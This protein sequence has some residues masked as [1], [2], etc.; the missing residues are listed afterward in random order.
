MYISQMSLGTG[1]Y[2]W[3]GLGPKRKYFR[4]KKNPNP[5]FFK[6]KNYSTQPLEGKEKSTPS[7]S[8]FIT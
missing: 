3:P 4:A 1:H 6:T 7:Y 8:Y 2:L 5:T